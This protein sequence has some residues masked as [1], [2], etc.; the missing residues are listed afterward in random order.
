MN[1]SLAESSIRPSEIRALIFQDIFLSGR[2]A[3]EVFEVW[4][5]IGTWEDRMVVEAVGD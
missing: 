4:G 5:A 1:W 3:V 2:G